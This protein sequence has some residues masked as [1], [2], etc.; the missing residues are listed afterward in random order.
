MNCIKFTFTFFILAIFI[1]LYGQTNDYSDFPQQETFWS[2]GAYFGTV[3]GCIGS[4]YLFADDAYYDDK[5]VKFHW[6]RNNDT[7]NLDWFDN[8]HRGID[9]FGHI[10]STSLLSEN[11]YFLARRCG[12]DN[13]EA[14]WLAFGSSV[15]VLG[16][17]EVWDAHFESWGFSVGDFVSNLLGAALPVSQQNIAFM[18]HI[19]YKMSYNFL[20]KKTKDAGI[21]DYENM[22][23]WITFNPVGLLDIKNKKGWSAFNLAI[24]YG[25]EKYRSQ[26]AEIYLSLDYNLK[27]VKV[28]NPYLQH[29][30]NILDRLHYPAP[31]IRMAPGY[32][33]YGLFF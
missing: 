10:Y 30:I 17:M 26:K 22:T 3:L 19:N 28:K 20:A 11:L 27:A 24:G 4:L 16:A 7:G 1:P 33:A 6:A 29:I 31:A 8:Y 12:Y 23:F 25:L 21:H 2:Q 5:K 32:I 13:Q 14:S 18:R 9:K 15:T